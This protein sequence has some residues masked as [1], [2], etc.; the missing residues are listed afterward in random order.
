MV[1]LGTGRC[2]TERQSNLQ[3]DVVINGFPID[4]IG[5]FTLFPGGLIGATKSELASLG[6]R[7]DEAKL[8]GDV[9]MLQ[10]IPTLR[11][12]Y[13]E[14][15]QRIRITVSNAYLLPRVFDLHGAASPG[16]PAAGWGVVLNY[17]LFA[18]LSSQQPRP[19]LG[20]T[21]AS[22]TL[23]LRA[24]SPY[25]TVEQSAIVSSAAGTRLDVVRL[26]SS[27][28]YSDVDRLMSATAGDM[29]NGG[30]S[31]T[32]PIRLGGLQVQRDFALRPDLVTI[33]L[34]NLGGT[35][36]VPSTVDVYVNNSRVFSQD[37]GVGPFNVTNIPVV[38][39]AGNAEM[40]VRDSAGR[41]TTTNVPFYTSASLLAPGLSSWSFEAG[42]PRLFWGSVADM[43]NTAP[44]GSATWRQG[45]TD[46]LT[47][48]GHA[49]GGSGLANSG[50]GA[51]FKIGSFG[52]ATLAAAGSRLGKSFGS[53]G[54]ASFE[55]RIFGIAVAASTQRSFADYEDLASATARL[56]RA[57]A[58]GAAGGN[59]QNTAQQQLYASIHA[60]RALD[61]LTV[62]G[63]LWFDAPSNWTVSYIHERYQPNDVSSLASLSYTRALP[64]N[65]SLYATAYRDFGTGHSVGLLLGVTIPLGQTASA[66]ASVSRNGGAAN[67]SFQA[68][69]ALGLEPG[70]FGWQVQDSEGATPFRQGSVAY[71]ASALSLQASASQTGSGFDGTLE[72]AGAIATIGP[73]V[74]FA[75]R[76][77]DAF[78]VVDAGAPGVTV[79]YENRT[80]GATD[81][82]GMLLVPTLQSYQT[83]KISIDPDRLP[84]DAEVET[85]HASVTPADR[86][87]TLVSFK[88]QRDA[89]A[90]LVTFAH[91]A[92]A[93][94]AGSHGRL[95]G[96]APFIVGYDGQA[97]IKGLS[98]DNEVL[99]EI[100]E[101]TCNAQFGFKP[102]TGQQVHIGPVACR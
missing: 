98:R 43:Y 40:V 89:D 55:T 67:G 23:D 4:V 77:P 97:F 50:L 54:S 49:E 86:A 6:L 47:A 8:S 76:I 24:F 53:L 12:A 30:L 25:G 100:G 82:R 88:V 59:G 91:G 62:S 69:Q 83:N 11:Y 64:F 21:G 46:W 52:A 57:A 85:T 16:R 2:A 90:A 45:L 5:S 101:D 70:S 87:G 32:R 38:T 14:R 31:W 7:A 9:V 36:A 102:V 26:D 81:S 13:E 93:V 71:R 65:A 95:V 94:P 74:F 63:P 33:P 28:R 27:Y 17:D 51:A 66:T 58:K 48:E 79:S 78:A 20:F 61:R 10:S 15:T 3:L 68:S 44:V 22:A 72:A 84:V 41:E 18:S 39:G 56:P 42:L 73:H 19:L 29:V 75:D 60:P 34:P 35:A 96:G 92:G 80:V 99:I 37:L 1:M